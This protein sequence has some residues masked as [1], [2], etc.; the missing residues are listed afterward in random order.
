MTLDDRIE[1]KVSPTCPGAGDCDLVPSGRLIASS[2]N[3]SLC[4]L[5][6]SVKQ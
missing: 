5:R 3:M 4:E 6:D 1:A 2:E